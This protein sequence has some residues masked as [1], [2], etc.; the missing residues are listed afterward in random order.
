MRKTVK[1]VVSFFLEDF[2]SGEPDEVLRK[3]YELISMVASA[4]ALNLDRS[5][6]SLP[7]AKRL[8]VRIALMVRWLWILSILVTIGPCACHAGSLQKLSKAISIIWTFRLCAVL[9]RCEG[10]QRVS[11]DTWL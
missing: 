2:V 10:W 7:S 9:I 1:L 8:F 11:T 6:K 4:V 3:K 5:T